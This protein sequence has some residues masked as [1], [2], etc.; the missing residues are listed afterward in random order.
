MAYGQNAP[1]CDPLKHLSACHMATTS[2]WRKI[3]LLMLQMFVAICYLS[4]YTKPIKQP[5]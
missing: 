2:Q 3:F 4:E 5:Y 1:S